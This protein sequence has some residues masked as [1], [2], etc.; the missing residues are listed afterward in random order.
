[1]KNA[2]GI[3]VSNLE[4]NTVGQDGIDIIDGGLC[5]GYDCDEPNQ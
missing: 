5:V 1:M 4:T 2:I 3:R